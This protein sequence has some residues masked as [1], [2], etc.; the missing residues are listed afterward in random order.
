MRRIKDISDFEINEADSK[1]EI[2]SQ[3]IERVKNATSKDLGDQDTQVRRAILD[4]AFG[5]YSY[6]DKGREKSKFIQQVLTLDQDG[7]EKVLNS[8]KAYVHTIAKIRKIETDEVSP[9]QEGLDVI[10]NQKPE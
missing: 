5:L 2:N 8:A 7:R 1:F 9:N 4:T 10:L 6:F 3:D